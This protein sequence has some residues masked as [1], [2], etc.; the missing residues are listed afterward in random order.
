MIF[1]ETP[2]AGAY[3]IDLEKR[4]DDRGFFARCFCEK[5]FAAH[6]LSTRFVQVNNSL[7]AKRGTLRGMHYQLSPKAET[8]LVRCIRGALYDIILDLR[9]D[10]PTF[11]QSFGAELSADGRRMMYVPKGFAHGFITLADNTEA[12]YFVDEFYAPEQERGVRWNDPRFKIH[13]PIPHT[14]LS[15][16]DAGWRSFDPAWHLPA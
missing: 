6:N 2:L 14:V 13:W 12:F 7:S 15:D 11:G 3:V 1:T 10:S 16:K 9:K 8:K 5:E 4:G